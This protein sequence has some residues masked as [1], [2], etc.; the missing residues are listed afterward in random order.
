MGARYLNH[1]RTQNTRWGARYLIDFTEK[2]QPQQHWT[3]SPRDSEAE[4]MT[5]KSVGLYEWWKKLQTKPSNPESNRG[6][7]VHRLTT[8]PSGHFTHTPRPCSEKDS[9]CT[10][11][12][13]PAQPDEPYTRPQTPSTGLRQPSFGCRC[14]KAMLGVWPGPRLSQKLHHAA[15]P[16]PSLAAEGTLAVSY[17]PR[18]GRMVKQRIVLDI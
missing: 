3:K 1:T 10:A 9:H 18:S 8:P 2:E 12:S 13:A 15:A 5:V 14:R 6:E 7:V 4:H 16:T 17:T 11:D